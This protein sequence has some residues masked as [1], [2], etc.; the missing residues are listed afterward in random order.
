MAK[1]HKMYK[2]QHIKVK[3]R[4]CGKIVFEDDHTCPHCQV[5]APGI[6]SHCPQCH[7]TN[8]VY[9][10]FGYNYTRGILAALIV[11]FF[12]L[13]RVSVNDV[14][15]GLAFACFFTLLAALLGFWGRDNTECICQ[16]CLQGWFPFDE[17]VF[18]RFNSLVDEKGKVTRKFK[19]I[20]EDCFNG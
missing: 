7:S 8:Y 14:G 15:I 13:S 11:G 17:S 4:S 10:K 12:A 18:S 2:V 1:A 20:P 19:S 6:K 3:C 16:D 5:G 9:H